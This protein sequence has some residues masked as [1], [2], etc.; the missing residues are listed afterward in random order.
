[1]QRFYVSKCCRNPD[2]QLCSCTQFQSTFTQLTAS[3]F[4]NVPDASCVLLCSVH[5]QAAQRS[6]RL[7]LKVVSLQDAMAQASHEAAAGAIERGQL[8]QQVV[9]NFPIK[10]QTYIYKQSGVSYS[11]RN[12]RHPTTTHG[13]QLEF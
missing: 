6:K 2:L 11:S 5:F 7:K 13:N 10:V 4:H 8:Q 3:R 1:M 9:K 12:G